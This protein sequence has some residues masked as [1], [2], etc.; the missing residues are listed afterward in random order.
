ME[1]KNYN[2]SLPPLEPGTLLKDGQFE[3]KELTNNRGG[4]GRIYR[5][6]WYH[7]HIN[8]RRI[9][10]IKEFH[11]LDHEDA[12][13]SKMYSWTRCDTEKSIDILEAKFKIEAKSLSLLRSNL[14]DGGNL[15]NNYI[16][17]NPQPPS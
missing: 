11:V 5:A 9:V 2:Q 7:P 8:K 3:I 6:I 4:F 14:I 16:P 17:S 1:N 10:A 15:I 12:E 13:W